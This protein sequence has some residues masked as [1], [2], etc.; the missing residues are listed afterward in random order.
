M[1]PP[2]VVGLME[3]VA[4]G[5]GVVGM[6]GLSRPLVEGAPEVVIEVERVGEGVA[7]LAL[8]DTVEVEVME[9]VGEA[10]GEG[11]GGLE[12]L[13][14][15]LPVLLGVDVGVEERHWVEVPLGV[16]DPVA[17]P[18]TV[19]LGVEVMEGFRLA[20]KLAG[21]DP[22]TLCVLS[23]DCVGE[24]EAVVVEVGVGVGKGVP[25]EERHRVG[26]VEGVV[27]T[28]EELEERLDREGEAV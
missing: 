3:S 6:E 4:V 28:V 19:V 15:V 20:R 16:K 17:V 27:D 23:P 5:V 22:E 25:V 7:Q 26:L 2:T 18:H 12:P 8:A 24:E 14:C 9:E 21:M 13:L 1:F 10:V 11:L